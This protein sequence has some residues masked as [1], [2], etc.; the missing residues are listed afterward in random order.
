MF[1]FFSR[2][3]E[4]IGIFADNRLDEGLKFPVDKSSISIV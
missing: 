2:S 3:S 4:E 1:F